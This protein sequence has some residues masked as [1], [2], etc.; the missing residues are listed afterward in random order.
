MDVYNIISLETPSLLEEYMT[1]RSDDFSG[2]RKVINNIEE[3]GNSDMPLITGHGATKQR[4]NI[5]MT[6]LGLMSEE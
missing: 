5:Y 3:Y 6:A 4:Y 1:I 2:K